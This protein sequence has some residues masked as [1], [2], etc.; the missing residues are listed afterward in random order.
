MQF[1]GCGFLTIGPISEKGVP[2]KRENDSFR[3]PFQRAIIHSEN[4]Y[5]P[6]IATLKKYINKRQVVKIPVGAFIK[7]DNP[8]A[9]INGMEDF[10]D[11]FSVN[12]FAN[13]MLLHIRKATKKPV[14]L[15]IDINKSIDDIINIAENA[16]SIGFNGIIIGNGFKYIAKEHASIDCPECLEK[17]VDIIKSLKTR[18]NNDLPIVASN[19]I[20]IPEDAN[21]CIGAGAD[22]VEISTGFIY[23]GPGFVARA[24]KQKNNVDA[25]PDVSESSPL[26]SVKPIPTLLF[27]QASILLCSLLT[28][29]F[30]FFSSYLPKNQLL[31]SPSSFFNVNLTATIFAQFALLILSVYGLSKRQRG[32]VSWMILLIIVFIFPLSKIL[33][34]LLFFCL[35]VCNFIEKGWLTLH[36]RTVFEKEF[37]LWTWNPANLGRRCIQTGYLLSM[38]ILLSSNIPAEIR[39]TASGVCMIVFLLISRGLLP[40]FRLLWYSVLLLSLLQAFILW[41]LANESWQIVFSGLIIF[42]NSIGLAWLREPLIL[43]AAKKTD[44]IKI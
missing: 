43:T 4:G 40:G 42:F 2:R 25:P 21:L 3:I 20:I 17:T 30:L 32:W 14:L 28:I 5:L 22:L 26:F 33:A 27:L 11:F 7:D 37:S 13:E 10:F 38:P 29:L 24:L 44:F 34:G 15:R 23:G 41:S 8:V 39:I 19:G 36:F 16:N 12:E 1:L 31:F 35:L 6:A 9:V 18:F